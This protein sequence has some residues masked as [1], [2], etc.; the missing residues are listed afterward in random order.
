MM[1]PNPYAGLEKGD[2]YVLIGPHPTFSPRPGEDPDTPIQPGHIVQ[3][4][5]TTAQ[6]GYL[7]EVVRVHKNALEMRYKGTF[8]EIFPPDPDSLGRLPPSMR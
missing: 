2:P 3:L 7:F 5:H 4:V 6:P 1:K 8:S